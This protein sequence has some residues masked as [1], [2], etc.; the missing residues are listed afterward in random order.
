MITR[1]LSFLAL[2]SLLSFM[3]ACVGAAGSSSGDTPVAITT[4]TLPNGTVNSS[5]TATLTASGGST[6]YAWSVSSGQLPPG[7][8]LSAGGS[9]SGTPTNSGQFSFTVQVLDGAAPQHK[10]TAALNLT[11]AAAAGQ[12]SLTVTT[13]VLPAGTVNTNYAASLNASGGTTP[14]SWSVSSGQLPSGVNLAAAGHL[15]GMPTATGSYS[16]SV[17][18]NDQSG[19]SA[20]QALNIAV[21]STSGG[22]LPTIPGATYDAVHGYYTMPASLAANGFSWSS[23]NLHNG[24]FNVSGWS[25]AVPSLITV[26]AGPNTCSG[27]QCNLVRQLNTDYTAV[28]TDA[29]TLQVTLQFD[30]GPNNVV[31]FY[32]TLGAGPGLLTGMT[33]SNITVPSGWTV[34][35]TQDFESGSLSSGQWL[36]SGGTTVTTQYHNDGNPA[37]THSMRAGSFN[38]GV[39]TGTRHM[40]TSFYTYLD[41]SFRMN[42]EMFLYRVYQ[43]PGYS[44]AD[45]YFLE[46][47]LD[48]GNDWNGTYG[49]YNSSYAG[50]LWNIQGVNYVQDQLPNTAGSGKSAGM[51]Y[52]WVIPTGRWYQVEVEQKFNTTHLIGTI[53]GTVAASSSA[54]TFTRSSGSWISDGITNG[55]RICFSG[56]TNNS[57]DSFFGNNSCY[58]VS[59]VT[60]TTLT[61]ASNYPSNPV[62]DET[63]NP[64]AV[65]YGYSNNDGA[66]TIYLDGV[67]VASNSTYDF[68]GGTVDFA[69]NATVMQLFGQYTK[70]IWRSGVN[71]ACQTAPP[72]TGACSSHISGGTCGYEC[73]TTTGSCLISGGWTADGHVLDS[74]GNATSQ[75][76]DCTGNGTGSPMPN[77]PVFNRYLDDVIVMAQ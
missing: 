77:P 22:T 19:K 7:V 64:G 26:G 27:G 49:N 67:P 36:D 73:V 63:S 44:A 10:A 31:I 13:T 16:F 74:S 17:K 57:S 68:S 41:A 5:Y 55:E 20:S 70:L 58:V 33:P 3:M 71:G 48:Y 11:I 24:V 39:P 75:Y 2:L 50:W 43:N 53:P 65:S 34:L 18:V 72:F 54:R 12:A 35:T 38:Y 46:N 45:K 69:Q 9:L 15:S 4:Q 28:K 59:A 25:G 30:V 1:A 61:F 29:T 23:G 62:Y 14:Y 60:A 37:H 8:T 76:V 56:F 21:G 32:N 6:P 51:A 42:D 47:I 52:N 66:F 40:Y